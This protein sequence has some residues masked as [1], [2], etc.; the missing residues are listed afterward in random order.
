MGNNQTSEN[1]QKGGSNL[2]GI[3]VSHSSGKPDAKTAPMSSAPTLADVDALQK[4]RPIPSWTLPPLLSYSAGT[5]Q[6]LA[7]RLKNHYGTQANKVYRLQCDADGHIEAFAALSSTVL[8]Q[9]RRQAVALEMMR[10]ELEHHESVSAELKTAH[11]Q[12]TRLVEL[13]THLRELL[14]QASKAKVPQLEAFFARK[15]ADRRWRKEACNFDLKGHSRP[16]SYSRTNHDI[17]FESVPSPKATA[18]GGRKLPRNGWALGSRTGD[19]PTKAHAYRASRELSDALSSLELEGA[20]L[21]RQRTRSGSGSSGRSGSS[22]RRS[23]FESTHSYGSANNPHSYGST[24]LTGFD[25]SPGAKPHKNP[26]SNASK[27]SRSIFI[28]INLNS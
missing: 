3:I 25:S 26:S 1:S 20:E 13:T 21:A 17:G 7:A 9:M 12:V 6:E 16:G 2:E 27:S 4:V 23:S 8:V 14:P 22:S 11:D 15:A 18:G 5:S 24:R 19:N 10:L 28:F